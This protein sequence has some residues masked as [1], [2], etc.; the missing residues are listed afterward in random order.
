MNFAPQK[1]DDT[2]FRKEARTGIL[3]RIS[4]LK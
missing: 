2:S 3:G 1:Q 4:Y